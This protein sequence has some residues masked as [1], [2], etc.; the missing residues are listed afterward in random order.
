MGLKER[1]EREK[2][3]RKKAIL[4]AARS[5]LF[6]KGLN[7]TSVPQ[8]AKRAELAVG[9]IYTY[10]TSKEEI[11]AGLQEEGLGILYEKIEQACQESDSLFDKF[12]S[13][14]NAF[15]KFTEEQKDYFDIINYFLSTPRILLGDELK[16][17]VDQHGK[18]ILNAIETIINQGIKKGEIYSKNPEKDAITFWATLYGLVQFKKLQT[19]VLKDISFDELYNHA[20]E[21]II[22]MLATELSTNKEDPSNG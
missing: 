4:E 8:I 3:A 14:A 16:R 17:Q 11:F 22:D 9:T 19:T 20:V 13:I 12:R 21:R 6:E 10:Y 5:L 2:L 18:K 7:A 15:R 1:R